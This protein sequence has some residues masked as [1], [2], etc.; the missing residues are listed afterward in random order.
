MFH[1]FENVESSTDRIIDWSFAA[2]TVIQF[3]YL[4]QRAAHAPTE[5]ITFR[6]VSTPLVAEGRLNYPRDFIHDTFRPYVDDAFNVNAL[7]NWFQKKAMITPP[8]IFGIH[9][10]EVDG[11][12][13]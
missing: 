13:Q 9:K 5:G 3:F 4:V 8:P 11:G 2:R 10:T 6:G 12:G 1:Y 7:W